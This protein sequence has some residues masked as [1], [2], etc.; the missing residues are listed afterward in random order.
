MKRASVII[1]ILFPLVLF[2]QGF[3]NYINV[4][5]YPHTLSPQDSLRDGPHGKKFYIQDE[6]FF[7]WVDLYPDMFFVHDTAYIFITKDNVRIERGSLWPD[8]NRKM[9][10]HNEH[11]KYA[12]ISPFE[13]SSVSSDG[14]INDKIAI[15]V[16]PHV[17]TPR[18]KLTDGPLEESFKIH[19]NSQLIWIDFLPGA[20]FA[21]PTAY[22][23]ISSENIRTEQG[24]FWPELNGKRI[25]YGQQNKTGIIS[26][27]K[28]SRAVY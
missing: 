16:Y 28:V 5:F 6:T 9:I 25:L 14:Y 11:G 19:N 20:F 2:S 27:F 21:H 18:D 1:L 12:L 24:Y 7:I 17:L 4:H 13:M 22:I 10:L 3:D 15:H 23:L 8:F 26:P